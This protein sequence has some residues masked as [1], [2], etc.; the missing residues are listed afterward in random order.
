MSR[1]FD[2]NASQ[3]DFNDS[4]F[5]ENQDHLEDHRGDD[6]RQ[7]RTSMRSK[8]LEKSSSR[9]SFYKH[10]KGDADS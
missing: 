9:R 3:I 5:L 4:G 2:A 7:I 6:H 8:W 10:T 1:S